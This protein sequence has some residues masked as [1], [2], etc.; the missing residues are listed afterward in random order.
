MIQYD[1]AEKIQEQ[2]FKTWLDNKGAGVKIAVLDT[3][4]DL[5]HQA[6]KHLD[7]AGHKFNAAAPGFNPALPL[8]SGNG[9]VN[10]LHRKK[11]HGTQCVSVLSA[12]AE[13]QNALLGFV[14]EAE[15]FILKIN[16][17]DHKFFR[18]KDF[19][20]GLEAASNL[21]VDIVVASVSYPKADIALEGISQA[22]INRV[23]GLLNASGAV[24]F[25]SLPNQD[26]DESWAGLSAA[27]FP[28]LR[29]ESINVGAI[30]QGVFQNRRAEI[31]AEATIHFVTANASAYFCRIQNN[32]VQEAVSSS[33]ATYLVAG[34]AALYIASIKKREQAEYKTRPQIDFLKGLSQ[35][36]LQLL[37]TPDWNGT[38]PVLY[39]T[40][41]VQ[42]GS[43]DD[44]AT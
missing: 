19:L 11:G 32:Y 3:G 18:V 15:I 12:K 40:S 43:V 14:P 22:E 37:A 20:K 9:D 28:S 4:V 1:W 30:S 13:D 23:F 2:V 35:K 44:S 10:D 34:V 33:Y 29:P 8:L 31:D 41:S 24:L 26:E 39:K 7:K 36:F 27:N 25:A 16:T 6:L 17:V 21:G 38:N 5:A 42:S